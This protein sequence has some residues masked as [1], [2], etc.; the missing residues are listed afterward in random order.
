MIAVMGDACLSFREK[1]GGV[2]DCEVSG[3]GY[4]VAR[5]LAEKGAFPALFSPLGDDKAGTII[6]ERLVEDEILFDPDI[7]RLPFKSNIE[8]RYADG[9][10]SDF[11][12]Y[13]SSALLSSEALQ[14]ALSVHT[15]IKAVHLSGRS[16]CYNPTSTS[17]IDQALFISPR[18]FLLVDLNGSPSSQV[19]S[20]SIKSILPYSDL[21]ITGEGDV[22]P[23]VMEGGRLVLLLRKDSVDVLRKGEAVFS[24]PLEKK[25]AGDEFSASILFYLERSGFLPPDG[26]DIVDYE[27]D[28]GFIE[29]MIKAV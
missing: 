15:N 11:F 23:E 3:Y 29:E 26:E 17:F 25:T 14:A 24:V 18:P 19:L 9:T 5:A 2:F 1:E 12:Q 16:L 6:V 22:F 8:I 7:V 27:L 4:R 21:F 13:S 10:V 28:D 20:R